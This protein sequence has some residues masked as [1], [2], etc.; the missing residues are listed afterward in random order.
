MHSFDTTEDVPK[1]AINGREISRNFAGHADAL[2]ADDQTISQVEAV[3]VLG[4][5]K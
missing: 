4:A 5:L 2:L 3:G 1:D